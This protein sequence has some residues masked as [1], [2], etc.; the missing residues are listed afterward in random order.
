[1][2]QSTTLRLRALWLQVHKWIGISLAIL[3]IPVS[4]TGAAL[5][6]HDWLDAQINPQRYAV[7]SSEARLTPAQY[8]AA[9]RRAAE[10]RGGEARLASIRYPEG[11]GPIVATALEP[12]RGEGRPARTSIWIDP[13]N[14]AVLDAASGN[15]GLVQVFH[16]LHGSLMVPG[17]GRTIVGWIGV[18]MFIS[19]LTGLW[20]WWPITGSVRRGFRWKRQNSANANLHHQ[21]GFWIALPLAM[22]SFTGLWI[23]FPSVFSTFEASQPKGKSEGGPGGPGRGAPPRPLADP[24][25]SADA[26]LAAARPLSGGGRLVAITWP[27]ENPRKVEW[28]FQFAREGGPVEIA[29][30]DASGRASPP[31]PPRPET[32]ARLMRRLHDG[33]GMGLVWQIIIFIGGIIPAV[34]AATGLVMWWRSRG[35]KA[36]LAKKRKARA[37]GTGEVA[38]LPAE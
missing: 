35:W 38:P 32:N 4:V 10:A 21:L 30:D 31:P 29:V 1:V 14:G 8:A 18:F 11:E 16:S 5:V 7:T 33:T 34:L 37:L 17:W 15:S 27:V 20:L 9:A 23:S 24:A 28:K 26:A 2:A 22:L 6:W 12:P 13:G 36:A 3:I 25:T 19:C